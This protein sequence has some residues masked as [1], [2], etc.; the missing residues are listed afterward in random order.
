MKNLINIFILILGIASCTSTRKLIEKGDYDKA[1]NKLCRKLAGQ[2][3]KPT[4]SIRLLEMAFQKAQNEDLY[5]EKELLAETQE[6]KWVKIYAIHLRI[7]ERQNKIKPLLP[8]VS[9]D[10]YK[11]GF[12][13][14]NTLERKRESKTNSIEYFYNTA[15]DKMDLSRKTGKHESAIEAYNF[16]INIDNLI[17]NYKDVTQL[18][19]KAKE[20]GTKNYLVLITNNTYKILPFQLEDKLL[21]IRVSE[22]DRNWKH[23]DMRKQ[24]DLVY[25]Y[26]IVLNLTNLEFSPERESSTTVEDEYEEKV[27]EYVKDKK[28][29]I[30]K[31]SSGRPIKNEHIVTFK[32]NLEKIVQSKSTLL[33]G[34]LEWFN[35]QT[36]NIE[37]SEPL[38][39]E[40]NFMNT[41]GRLVKGDIHKVSPKGKEILSGRSAFF[42]SN[43]QMTLDAGDKMKSIVKD[44][45]CRIEN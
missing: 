41:F 2:K 29:N 44:I 16:L 15:L 31:D 9:K 28:G 42:P 33:S 30:L 34:H 35:T 27:N 6:S 1:I 8:L 5:K 13:F 37:R 45:I 43:E 22:L 25:D 11:A 10:D 38:N 40:I 19:R 21:D 20:L 12:D 7:D 4:E 18:K 24:K 39:V 26:E 32:N 3:D 14:I 23:F 36:K 17:N